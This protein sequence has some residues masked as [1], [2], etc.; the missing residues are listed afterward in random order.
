M[1]LHEFLKDADKIGFGIVGMMAVYLGFKYFKSKIGELGKKTNH[2]NPLNHAFFIRI[3]YISKYQ[4]RAME[5][6]YI[7]KDGVDKCKTELFRDMLKV[8][9]TIWE[10]E[11]KNMVNN[12]VNK[13]FKI[14]NLEKVVI[15]NL[16]YVVTSYEDEWRKMGVPEIVIEKFNKWHKPHVDLIFETIKSIIAGKI[17]NDKILLLNAI[18]DLYLAMIVMTMADAEETLKRLNGELNGIKYNDCIVG[19]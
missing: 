2:Y 14:T 10:R 7:Q 13:Q 15:D 11:V 1:S 17:Y 12:I 18:L 8:K 5:I 6:I 19:D 3:K 9:F 16:I 4:L